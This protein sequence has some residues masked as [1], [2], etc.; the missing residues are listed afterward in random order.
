[1]DTIRWLLQ[2]LPFYTESRTFRYEWRGKQR[3]VS[4]KMR[5][6]P[7]ADQ[8]GFDQWFARY[9]SNP[10]VVCARHDCGEIIWPGENVVVA[11]GRNWHLC[12]SG[13][14]G[15]YIGVLDPAGALITSLALT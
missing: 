6:V 3:E 15:G 2:R 13:S 12:C 1:M 9:S 14:G 11:G 8:Q 7:F 10:S 4:V 5:G